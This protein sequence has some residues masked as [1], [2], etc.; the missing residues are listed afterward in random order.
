MKKFCAVFALFHNEKHH[1]PIWLNYYGENFGYENLYVLDHDSNDGSTDNLQDL[2]VNHIRLHHTRI[3]DD[4]GFMTRILQAKQEELLQSYE[5]IINPDADEF[6]LPNPEIYMSLK[7]YVEKLKE[8]NQKVGVA[9]GYEVLHDRHKEPAIIWDKPLLSQRKQ[10]IPVD[11]Y[12][13]PIILGEIRLWSHGKHHLLDST[14]A[15]DKNLILCH[16]NRLDYNLL[17]EKRNGSIWMTSHRLHQNKK[18]VEKEFDKLFD[19]PCWN[20]LSGAGPAEPEIIPGNYKN[21]I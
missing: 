17:K 19:N 8:K 16:T 21:F 14:P 20:T 15:N 9:T 18:N 1:L 11:T 6:L 4:N 10:W 7:Y 5:Y 2:G 13:K 3:N 12:N